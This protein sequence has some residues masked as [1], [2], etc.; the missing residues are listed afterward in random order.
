MAEAS[1]ESRD[2]A[3]SSAKR[4]HPDHWD[5][6]LSNRSMLFY[7]GTYKWD[8]TDG[9]WDDTG[10]H[11]GFNDPNDPEA[12]PPTPRP[13]GT[14]LEDDED[15]RVVEGE[16]GDL[17]AAGNQEETL[18][19]D[20]AQVL[21]NSV[22]VDFLA[23]FTREGSKTVL[24]DGNVHKQKLLQDNLFVGHPDRQRVLGQ[25]QGIIIGRQVLVD[26]HNLV[27]SYKLCDMEVPF[28][29]LADVDGHALIAAS[30]AGAETRTV[31]IDEEEFQGMVSKDINE[32][33]LLHEDFQMKTEDER[34]IDA[35]ETKFAKE[36][37]FG[38]SPLSE[39]P[40]D[41]SDWEMEDKIMPSHRVETPR[42]DS[43]S[44]C[45]RPVYQSHKDVPKRPT[46]KIV[47]SDSIDSA[48]EIPVKRRS[49]RI[50]L[51]R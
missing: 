18:R 22:H 10:I 48:V 33:K 5:G 29:S 49:T 47:R 45:N 19:R 28:A 25:I 30:N 16:C 3:A 12:C 14:W 38:S 21:N 51:Q 26:G 6:L 27:D 13:V 24:I 7:D 35:T 11:H 40:S 43:K 50:F 20:R 17:S 44:G 42:L 2:R 1:A 39:C 15:V 34:A 46:Q 23:K 9:F 8:G 41:L 32:P 36:F 4:K 37:P 31:S